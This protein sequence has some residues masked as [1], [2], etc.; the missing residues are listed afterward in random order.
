LL[1]PVQQLDNSYVAAVQPQG[2]AYGVLVS[3]PI[4]SQQLKPL[5]DSEQQLPL[6]SKL[7]SLHVLQ[8]AQPS[9]SGKPGS[10]V[11]AVVL[12]DGTVAAA[13]FKQTGLQTTASWSSAAA[14]SS[15][16]Q[17][18][19]P[20]RLLHAA[21]S[22]EL[23]AVAKQQAGQ[24]AAV[25]VYC[26]K[27]S[28]SSNGVDAALQLQQSILQLVHSCSVRPP[29]TGSKL[30]GVS[31][32][33]GLL[34]LMWSCHT[35]TVCRSRQLSPV[36]T[37][38]LPPALAAALPAGS[39]EEV[40]PAERSA[41][42]RKQRPAAATSGCNWTAAALSEQ[43]VLLLAVHGGAGGSQVQYA[44]L[45][46]CYSSCLSSG[47]FTA[48]SGS[49]SGRLQLLPLPQ[50]PFAPVALLV[51]GAVWLLP[52]QLPKADL[53]GLVSHLGLGSTQAH[54]AAVAVTPNGTQLLL[55]SRQQ[56]N[57]SAIAA[58]VS[59]GSAGVQQQQQGPCVLQQL[60]P[61]PTAATG[62]VPAAVQE[63]QQVLSK[64][65]RPV[66]ELQDATTQL[67]EALEQ[68]QQ[69]QGQASAAVLVSAQL[70]AQALSA[71]AEAQ[72]WALLDRLH[73]LAP[74]Q[75]LA[76][77]ADVVPALA[78]SQQYSSMRKLLLAAHDIP[79]EAVVRAVQQVLQAQQQQGHASDPQQ[80][81]AQQI[82]AAAEAVVQQAETAAAAGPSDDTVQLIAAARHAA[83][84]VDG[85]TSRELL[86]H[87]LL[88]VQV[89]SVEA[90]AVLRALPA[91]A[92][93]RLLRYMVKWLHKYSRT[94]I[95]CPSTDP[96]LC[97]PAAVQVVEW[98]KLLL[99]AQLTKL[100]MMPVAAPLLQQLQQLLRVEVAATSK[101][102][103][104]K[105]VTD[106]WAS[107]A[108]LPAAAVAANSQYVLEL[109][110]LRVNPLAVGAR[111]K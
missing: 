86:L 63:V 110:D 41:S 97:A 94:N 65:K 75:S 45:D 51:A 14:A 8:P 92:V 20:H 48:G 83:A 87:V 77:C 70:L 13:D 91:A 47:S 82:R 67:C 19:S 102:V 93:L 81:A 3:A 33:G 39:E 95:S 52:L 53:A 105:G 26:A 38:R 55:T 98:C 24:H 40:N 76:A 15:G 99:D 4:A 80:A 34:V 104:L 31:V 30:A 11:A 101:L 56:L 22:G 23:L 74:L 108:P 103:A 84:A 107:G 6:P 106:T 7:H 79:A 61:Q 29:S 44:L 32:A 100:L 9:G 37:M 17:R 25:D 96:L 5:L 72:E 71:L 78:A 1:A 18:S 36:N 58:A 54:A 59:N 62:D 68:Q 28:T 111:G 66:Q 64:Q 27:N 16:Q 69:Q 50:H 89:D 12:A 90:Q 73:S 46:S 85:F 10:A 35:V 109:L 43:H 21:C 60:Q 2:S 42:K 49:I 57:L 88:S